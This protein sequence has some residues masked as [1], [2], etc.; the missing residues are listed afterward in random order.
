MPSESP[1]LMHSNGLRISLLRELL[2]PLLRQV[3]VHFNNGFLQLGENISLLIQ[4]LLL[5]KNFNAYSILSLFL[6]IN[7]QCVQ[8]FGFVADANNLLYIINK[9]FSVAHLAGFQHFFCDINDLC[10]FSAGTT[11][12]T[13]VFGRR[14]INISAPR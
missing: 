11:I 14:S 5:L 2:L 6:K 4:F 12:S 3:A 13:F 8:T 7:I 9:D 10:T 1:T